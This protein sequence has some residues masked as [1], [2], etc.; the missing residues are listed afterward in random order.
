MFKCL[1]EELSKFEMVHQ[2]NQQLTLCF[3]HNVLY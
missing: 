3:L 2:K 1:Q